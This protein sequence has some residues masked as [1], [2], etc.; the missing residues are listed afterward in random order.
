LSVWCEVQTCIWPSGFHC[1]S[2]SLVPV[3]S[4][5]VLSFGYRLT[6]VVPE[7]GPLDAC[8]CDFLSNWRC[9]QTHVDGGCCCHPEGCGTHSPHTA[10]CVVGC[11]HDEVI[12]GAID[13]SGR[14]RRPLDRVNALSSCYAAVDASCTRGVLLAQFSMRAITTQVTRS[15]VC[16]SVCLYGSG[17]LVSLAK[18]AKPIEMSLVA[19]SCG[20]GQNCCHLT[21]TTE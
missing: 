18:T 21:N 11:L 17:T 16:T 7:K 15:A 10:P 5:S 20:V 19:N 3:K 14:S 4:T 13:Q 8:A 1:H 6:R 12:V 2:L 9:R